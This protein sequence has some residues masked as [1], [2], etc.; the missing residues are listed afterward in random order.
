M[1][2]KFEPD[3]EQLIFLLKQEGYSLEQVTETTT[4][5]PG[6]KKH[7]PPLNAYTEPILIKI[8]KGEATLDISFYPKHERAQ[9]K[10]R[11]KSI[12]VNSRDRTETLCSLPEEVWI[13]YFTNGSY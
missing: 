3:L 1:N 6:Q 11:I 13:E 4:V 5:I 7:D 9:G 8:K 2:F 12:A 10:G